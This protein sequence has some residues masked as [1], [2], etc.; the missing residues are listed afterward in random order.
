MKRESEEKGEKTKK[1]RINEGL[2]K[3]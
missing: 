2:G 3:A 1:G